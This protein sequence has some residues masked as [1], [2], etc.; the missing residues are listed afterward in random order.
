MSTLIF[1]P[2]PHQN[3]KLKEKI[4]FGLVK[5]M[6]IKLMFIVLFFPDSF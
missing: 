6:V 1:S 2:L 4:V 3:V 5:K